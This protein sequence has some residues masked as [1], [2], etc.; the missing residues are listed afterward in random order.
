VKATWQADKGRLSVMFDGAHSS[1]TPGVELL[2]DRKIVGDLTVT[3]PSGEKFRAARIVER[4]NFVVPMET[5]LRWQSHFEMYADMPEA[6]AQALLKRMSYFV[7]VEPAL[8][9]SP[10]AVVADSARE[11]A[12]LDV[13]DDVT[14]I[15][16]QIYA[17]SIWLYAVDPT[18]RKVVVKGPLLPGSCP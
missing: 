9:R 2:C 14:R 7:V 10:A 17:T 12:T 4:G 15:Q 6:E 8:D 3:A 1:S 13:R 18:T 16:T 11:A 5:E